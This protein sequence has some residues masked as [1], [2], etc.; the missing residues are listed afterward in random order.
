M[1]VAQETTSLNELLDNLQTSDM[2][3]ENYGELLGQLVSPCL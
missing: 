1:T 3:S 2:N